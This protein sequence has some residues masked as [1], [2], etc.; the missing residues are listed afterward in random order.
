LKSIILHNLAVMNYCEICDHNE[1]VLN[2]PDEKKEEK[3]ELINKEE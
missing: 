1:R 3:I 2:P